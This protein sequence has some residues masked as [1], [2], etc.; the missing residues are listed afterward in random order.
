MPKRRAFR[1]AALFLS[2]RRRVDRLRSRLQTSG[3]SFRRESFPR[4]KTKAILPADTAVNT[5][6]AHLGHDPYSYHGF[7]NPPVVH[8]ST[9]LF[10]DCRTMERRDQKYTYG[11]RGTPTTDALCEAFDELE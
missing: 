4:M 11:T 7:I 5:R 8:A 6:L 3:S 1:K 2:C 9:V 10:P